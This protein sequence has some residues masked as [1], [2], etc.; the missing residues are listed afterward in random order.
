MNLDEKIIFV[1]SYHAFLSFLS[2]RKAVCSNSVIDVEM[3]NLLVNGSSY[4]IDKDFH[5][6][7][8][9]DISLCPESRRLLC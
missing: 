4:D 8:L 1:F 3:L 7:A 6:S 9:R 5:K 2:M